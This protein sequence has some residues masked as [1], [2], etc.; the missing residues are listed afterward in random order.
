MSLVVPITVT[1]YTGV[2]MPSCIKRD[3][4]KKGLLVACDARAVA[5]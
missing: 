1:M 4:F 3:I 2:S 5:N